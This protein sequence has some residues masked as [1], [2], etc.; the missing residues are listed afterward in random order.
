MACKSANSCV[1]FSST[2]G[3]ALIGSLVPLAASLDN[4]MLGFGGIVVFQG[5]I[6]VHIAYML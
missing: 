4:R 1:L 2:V 5:G 6:V 3:L